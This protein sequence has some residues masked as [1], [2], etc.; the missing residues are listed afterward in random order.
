MEKKRGRATKVQER[1]HTWIPSTS[2]F[3]AV[4]VRREQTGSLAPP[5]LPEGPPCS[6]LAS[7]SENLS[8][9]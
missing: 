2:E 6:A 1:D 7:L 3:S 9:R 4:R 8:E 5:A